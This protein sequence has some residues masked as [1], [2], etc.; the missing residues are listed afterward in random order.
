MTV[1]FLPTRSTINPSSKQRE[2]IF[3]QNWH[4][5]F[6]RSIPQIRPIPRIPILSLIGAIS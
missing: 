2:V 4:P 1:S 3:L 5:K 6:A